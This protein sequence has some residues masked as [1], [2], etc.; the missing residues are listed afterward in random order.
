MSQIQSIQIQINPQQRRN[1]EVLLG[2][3]GDKG[4]VAEASVSAINRTL[5]QVRTRITR[6]AQDK[7][8]LKAARIRKAMWIRKASKRNTA[9]MIAT[10][11][12][13]IGFNSYAHRIRKRAVT[14]RRLTGITS[15]AE[16]Y[17]AYTVRVPHFYTKI[18]KAGGYKLV[19]GGFL[20]QA[21]FASKITG[22]K[23]IN[24]FRRKSSNK[25]D[26]KRLAG[27]SLAGIFRGQSGIFDTM[28]ADGNRLLEENVRSQMSRFLA[29]LTK[30]KQ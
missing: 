20:A 3:I 19:K 26:L 5:A 11:G 8:T 27:P 29:Q 7:V 13:P 21:G 24:V 30:A 18:Y 22:E 4:K 10:S 9:G 15:D 6:K 16:F 2:N 28:Q 17:T 23:P 12:N 1:L 14:V 25:W